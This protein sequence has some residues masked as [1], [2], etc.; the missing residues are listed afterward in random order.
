MCVPCAFFVCARSLYTGGNSTAGSV[1]VVIALEEHVHPSGSVRRTGTVYEATILQA[2]SAVNGQ[3]SPT[4]I[5]KKLHFCA[6]NLV[7]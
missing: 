4:D 1:S 2:H 5:D 6:S 7:G 3:V